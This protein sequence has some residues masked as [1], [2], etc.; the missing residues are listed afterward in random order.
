MAITINRSSITPF[1]DLEMPGGSALVLKSPNLIASWAGAILVDARLEFRVN[2]ATWEWID[3]K[4]LFR[5][6]P[7]VRG[8]TYAGG[9]LPEPDIELEVRLNKPGLEALR[10]VATNDDELRSALTDADSAG[11]WR[12]TEQWLGLTVK[13]QRGAIKTGFATT[14]SEL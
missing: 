8:P 5:L 3:S 4:Q 2:V 1:L 9:F 12:K 14:Y 13:Q 6:T 10:A 7:E 11:P